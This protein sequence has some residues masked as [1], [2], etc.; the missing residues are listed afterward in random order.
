MATGSDDNLHWLATG[1]KKKFEI[2]CQVLGPEANEDKEIKVLNR[3]IRWTESGLE[4]EADPRH[5][6]IVINEL[7]LHDAKGVTSPG[8]K[9]PE[10]EDGDELLG[11]GNITKYRAISA[12]IK[13]L[14]LD[15]ADI[16]YSA[17]ECA[18]AMSQPTEKNWQMLKRLGRYLRFR[19]RLVVEYPWQ[20]GEGRDH[21]YVL[22]EVAR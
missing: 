14:A 12:R 21:R 16:A 6:E 5:S 19:P 11:G 2:K 4:Y 18:R 17:K 8:T 15:R 3:I 9:L 20:E 1:M 7:G 10:S 22:E 13:Y